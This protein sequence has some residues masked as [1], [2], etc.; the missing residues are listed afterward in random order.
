M[1]KAWCVA[2]G[3]SIHR[4]CDEQMLFFEGTQAECS[5][6]NFEQVNE[7]SQYVRQ[8][9]YRGVTLTQWGRLP[10]AR[11]PDSNVNRPTFKRDTLPSHS[12]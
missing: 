3:G 12:T 9:P 5:S 2:K 4:V 7:K 11:T 1:S 10:S 6:G 8:N